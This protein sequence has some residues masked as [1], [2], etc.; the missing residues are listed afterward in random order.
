MFEEEY[1]REMSEMSLSKERT[2]KITELMTEVPVRKT[3]HAGRAVLAVALV[4]VALMGS[5][6]A[7][8]PT[9][10]DILAQTLGGFSSYA[11]VEEEVSVVDQG[12]EVKVVSAMADSTQI[13]I[14]AEVRDLTE[15]RLKDSNITLNGYNAIRHTTSGEFVASFSSNCLGYDPESRTALFEFV[16]N[17][18]VPTEDLSDLTL[19]ISGFQPGDVMFTSTDPLPIELLGSETL[20]SRTLETG[21]L[22]L[23]PGQTPAE[24]PG[25]EPF[26][27]SSMGFAADGKLHFLF[28]LGAEADLKE[29]HIILTVQSKSDQANGTDDHGMVYNSSDRNGGGIL[30]VTF[31]LEG[32]N[33]VDIVYGAQPED[34]S[35]LILSEVYGR[36]VLAEPITGNWVLPLELERLSELQMPL[37]GTVGSV[38]L[39]TLGISPLS[40]TMEGDTEDGS[41]AVFRYP[42][43]VFL[44]DGTVLHPTSK[45]SAAYRGEDG[46]MHSFNRW[47]FTSPV[48]VTQVTGVAVGLW[49]IPVADGAAGTGYWLSELPE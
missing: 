16:R 29:S 36:A 32:K 24:L 49:M 15:D 14:Y 9:L 42:L 22:V 38:S 37:S 1:R 46:E 44:E 35:D 5:A 47:E 11:Q 45:G 27:L 3:R 33:Y 12:I 8:S 6:L 34:L 30:D 28:K 7:M 41:P 20:R 19:A 48:D 2:E 21:E 39:K 31:T 23:E 18:T 10:R 25:A 13:K 4:C 26:S 40:V 17:G 43:S